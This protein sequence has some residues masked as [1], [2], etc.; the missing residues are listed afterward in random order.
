MEG[1]G[2]DTGVGRGAVNVSCGWVVAEGA[3]DKWDEECDVVCPVTPR[4]GA[5]H[6]AG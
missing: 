2:V 1:D 5:Q 4:A 6:I 3:G